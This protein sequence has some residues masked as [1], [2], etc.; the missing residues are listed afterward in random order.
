MDLEMEPSEL[1]EPI[2]YILN[3]GGKRLR[4]LLALLSY[5]LFQSDP[6]RIV[7]IVTG[8]EVFHNFTL[9]HDDIMDEADKAGDGRI[10]LKEFMDAV[11]SGRKVEV[12]PSAPESEESS[13]LLHVEN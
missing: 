5:N 10:S 4:P 11:R 2:R 8:I 6:E 3:L 7:G 9:M 12:V 1:Y 13:L